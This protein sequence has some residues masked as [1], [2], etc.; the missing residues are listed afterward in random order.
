MCVLQIV[1]QSFNL[2]NQEVDVRPGGSGVGDD[3]AKEVDF[4]SLGLVAHHGGPG[5]HHHCLDLRGHLSE[6]HKK[7]PLIGL[8]D[9]LECE[10]GPCGSIRVCGRDGSDVTGG[11][12][13]SHYLVQSLP[14]L[15][16]VGQVAQT[17]RQIPE[18][19]ISMLRL[20][21]ENGEQHF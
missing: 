17:R 12:L 2:L 21:R 7:S 3:H 13:M 20:I 10:W 15:L 1:P 6:M 4:V 16:A 18:A 11:G 8:C 19:H 9:S 5:L 14:L